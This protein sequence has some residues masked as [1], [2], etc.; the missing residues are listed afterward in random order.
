MEYKE[1]NRLA[2]VCGFDP[3]SGCYSFTQD[4][5]EYLSLCDELF[6][7]D[8]APLEIRTK[9]EFLYLWYASVGK[10]EVYLN[11]R[12]LS[13]VEKNTYLI[14]GKS[15]YVGYSSGFDEYNLLNPIT[16]EFSLSS[17]IPYELYVEDDVLT[18]YDDFYKKE[19]R[20]IDNS[21]EVLWS[22]P[23][24]DLGEDNIYTPGEVDR[25][26][27]ILGVAENLLWFSTQFG[28]LVALD[29][30][31][32]KVVYQ[33]SGN[34]ADQDKVEYTQV[35]GL[36]D[37]FYRES[38]RSI[39]CISYLGFQVI[40]AT[41]G[42]LAESCVF[43]EEDPDGIGRFDYIYAPNLQGDYFTFLAEMKTDRYGI[44]RVGIFD[45]NARKLLWTEEIIPFEERKATGNHL[46]TPQPLYISGDKLYIKDVKDTLHIFQRESSTYDQEHTKRPRAR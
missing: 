28:R 16:G 7:K 17:H 22:F 24:V 32:G 43:L 9:G 4:E 39:V 44:G 2:N 30:A 27:K 37:C 18:A 26:S 6:Q 40:D 25:I 20:R 38:D 13:S 3:Q 11:K 21:T 1:T 19:I 41:T 14:D 34:P 23:F 42:D 15:L 33:L 5:R 8:E 10:L 36:G 45:L 31:T 46:V 12:V 35:A 29:V